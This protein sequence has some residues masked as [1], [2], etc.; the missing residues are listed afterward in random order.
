[1][2]YIALLFIRRTLVQ[3]ILRAYNT[4]RT[5]TLAEKVHH[6]IVQKKLL[7]A[8]FVPPECMGM[9][10][11]HH[12]M[13]WNLYQGDP[14]SH[15]RLSPRERIVVFYMHNQLEHFRHAS[16][17]RPL[18]PRGSQSTQT[19][20]QLY[21]GKSRPHC[22]SWSTGPG[23]YTTSLSFNAHKD[24]YKWQFLSAVWPRSISVAFVGCNTG[25]IKSMARQSTNSTGFFSRPSSA[26]RKY[27]DACRWQ[28]SAYGWQA[29]AFAY[30]C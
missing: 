8:G 29:S 18:V 13:M 2:D 28:V 17:I 26:D 24:H 12:Q 16:E 20:D 7:A 1:M 15:Y 11:P 30:G 23:S 6:K 5:L 25:P 3:G 10:M 27:N 19:T 22:L 21:Y 14:I 4:S 9:D